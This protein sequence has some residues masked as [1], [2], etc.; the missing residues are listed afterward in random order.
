MTMIPGIWGLATGIGLL[1]VKR[2]ARYS[3]IVFAALTIVFMGITFGFGM[4]VTLAVA[5]RNPFLTMGILG[6]AYY[7]GVPI[8]YVAISVW[9][10][11]LFN[12]PRVAEEFA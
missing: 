12:R 1:A 11:M 7:V 5:K 3:V 2:W 8:F 6:F 10:L 4:I 9:F